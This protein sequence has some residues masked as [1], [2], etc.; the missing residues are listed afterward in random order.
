MKTTKLFLILFFAFSVMQMH[1]V[2]QIFVDPNPAIGNDANSGTQTAPFLTIARAQSYVRNFLVNNH[3]DP[4]NVYLFGGNYNLTETVQ[5]G[6]ADGGGSATQLVTYR[7]KAGYT[8]VISSDVALT[9]WTKVTTT[10]TGLP[11]A[12]VAVSI[13]RL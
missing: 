10:L 1:A 7:A 13:D 4:I 6:L 9:G 11:A 3:T 12:A 8:P 5:F 2:T